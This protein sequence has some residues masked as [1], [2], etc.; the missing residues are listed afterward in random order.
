MGYRVSDV[1]RIEWLQR[2]SFRLPSVTVL[3]GAA[4]LEQRPPQ[5]LRTSAGRLI[6]IITDGF[7][8]GVRLAEAVP[9]DM[10][11][12]PLGPNT[13][14]VVVGG[15]KLFRKQAPAHRAGRPD[16]R[17]SMKRPSPSHS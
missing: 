9:Q 7:D 17:C 14:H 12:V 1:N 10:I 3:A 13:R 5:W 16:G 2:L 15:A 4:R 6:D 11:A 8:A